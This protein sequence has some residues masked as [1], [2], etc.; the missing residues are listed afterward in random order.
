[1]KCTD[2]GIT[3]GDDKKHNL[4]TTDKDVIPE[5]EVGNVLATDPGN[6]LARNIDTPMCAVC[7]TLVE[8]FKT[9]RDDPN[10]ACIMVAKCHGDF[11]VVKLKWET[12]EQMTSFGINYAFKN[13][14]KLKANN[15]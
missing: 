5:V 3:M 1:M 12:I 2:R 7:D 13:G 14:R 10:E 15:S 11:E 9:Y 6:N 8:D 4:V